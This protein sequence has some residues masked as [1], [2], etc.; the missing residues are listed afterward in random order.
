[1]TLIFAVHLGLESESAYLSNRLSATY[2]DGSALNPSTN[3]SPIIPFPSSPTPGPAGSAGLTAPFPSAG[4]RTRTKSTPLSGLAGTSTLTSSSGRQ[5]YGDYEVAVPPLPDDET[6]GSTNSYDAYQRDGAVQQQQFSSTTMN[7]TYRMNG[8]DKADTWTSTSPLKSRIPTRPRSRSQAGSRSSSHSHTTSPPSQQ[9]PLPIVPSGI[10]IPKRRVSSPSRDPSSYGGGRRSPDLSSSARVREGFIK[11]ELPPFKMLPEEAMRIAE[12]GHDIPDD[13][14]EIDFGRT[15]QEDVV[16]EVE[17]SGE[18]RKRSM[19]MRSGGGGSGLEAKPKTLRQD[20]VVSEGS[21]MVGSQSRLLRSD[22]GQ[23]GIP[24]SITGGVGLG[25]PSS[26][27]RKIPSGT[28]SVGKGR[29]A[30]S[31]PKAGPSKPSPSTAARS[32]SLNLLGSPASGTPSSASSS[33]LGIAAHLVPPDTT[34]T[35]PKGANWDEVFLPTVAKKLGMYET[36]RAS[37]GGEDDLVVEWDKDGTPVKW[38]TRSALSKLDASQ[39][40]YVSVEHM[41][42]LSWCEC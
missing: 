21:G 26:T 2:H 11:N 37:G 33:R 14:V 10:P 39:G 36:A 5:G 27:I 24:R 28:G 18:K 13:T 17:S 31:R 34:Y 4:G 16:E 22:T 7:G 15:E 42:V 12:R 32:A 35:P 25:H 19:T 38:V 40:I 29:S 9:P 41:V 3:P 6:Y 20:S 8:L 1:M 30:S 23:S